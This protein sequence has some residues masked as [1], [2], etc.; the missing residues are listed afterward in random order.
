MTMAMENI[1]PC[2]S[3]S[4]ADKDDVGWDCSSAVT[5]VPAVAFGVWR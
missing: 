5:T 3:P 1:C 2:R 4:R